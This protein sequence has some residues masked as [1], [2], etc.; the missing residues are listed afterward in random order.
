MSL[1]VVPLHVRMHLYLYWAGMVIAGL[2]V[3]GFFLSYWQVG[4]PAQAAIDVHRQV[5]VLAYASI[6]AW[7]AGLA[8][9]WYSR[10]RVDSAVAARLRENRDGAI[11]D[12]GAAGSD[13][14]TAGDTLADM[15]T[16]APGGR[17]T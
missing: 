12:L 1:K 14:E 13:A 10:R 15:T 6:L 3:V 7:V 8:F 16:D 9:M 11:V 4:S 5:P 17:D 2:G